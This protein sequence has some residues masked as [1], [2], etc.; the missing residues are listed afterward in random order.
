MSN[1][2]R[3]DT[4]QKLDESNSISKSKTQYKIQT[5]YDYQ[6][7]KLNT[8]WEYRE[9]DRTKESE[10]TYSEDITN[11][12]INK[13]AESIY[14]KGFTEPLILQYSHKYKTAYLIEGNHRLLS[15]RK[16][17]LDYV[18]IRVTIDGVQKKDAKKVIGFYA[19]KDEKVQT[20]LPSEIGIP[21]CLDKNHNNVESETEVYEEHK[22]IDFNKLPDAS[23]R[24]EKIGNKDYE[25]I[26]VKFENEWNSD[27]LFNDEDIEH[28]DNILSNNNTLLEQYG[29]R[30]TD[31]LDTYNDEYFTDE[32]WEIFGK[33]YERQYPE[34]YDDIRAEYYSEV[35]SESDVY[36]LYKKEIANVLWN[37]IR[38]EDLKVINSGYYDS[39]F[40]GIVNYLKPTF[41]K[42]FT[43]I[44][45]DD[46]VK[47]VELET[48]SLR[49]DGIVFTNEEIDSYEFDGDEKTFKEILKLNYNYN[50]KIDIDF[51]DINKYNVTLDELNIDNIK[52][53]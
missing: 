17:E 5:S 11:E 15:A 41:K 22:T 13:L 35:F 38:E 39:P 40:A 28:K 53:N 52:K 4:F 34:D 27:F 29:N 47:K 46:N 8:I 49:Y 12:N 33:G 14:E 25:I 37:K 7:V 19:S 20:F 51:A 21:N 6:W 1:I 18:P 48:Y 42:G 10:R 45:D 36:D 9:F 32:M 50:T 16:L 31:F 44:K 26:E 2:K 30:I 43:Y 24:H 3:F 23:L